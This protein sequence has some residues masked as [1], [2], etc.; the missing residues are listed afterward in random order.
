MLEEKV[1]HQD[2]MNA[3]ILKSNQGQEQSLS[4]KNRIHTRVETYLQLTRIQIQV[5][6]MVI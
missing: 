2:S 6:M 4:G 1:Q 3:M 5:S